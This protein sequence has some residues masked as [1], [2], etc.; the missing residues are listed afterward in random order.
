MAEQLLMLMAD[1][2]DESQK[3]MADWTLK[4]VVYD[5]YYNA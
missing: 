5:M 4:Y 3:S 1:L 2:D